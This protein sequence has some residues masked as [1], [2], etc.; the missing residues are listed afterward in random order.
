LSSL[1]SSCTCSG[2][3][4]SLP[5]R[6]PH[7]LHGLFPRRRT[8]LHYVPECLCIATAYSQTRRSSGITAASL[9]PADVLGLRTPFLAGRTSDDPPNLVNCAVIINLGSDPLPYV[10]PLAFLRS[11]S[12]ETHILRTL[13]ILDHVSV[14]A[15]E[16][17]NLLT[18][19]SAVAYLYQICTAHYPNTTT[20]SAY[21]TS[22][23]TRTDHGR[24][25]SFSFW[26]LSPRSRNC[27]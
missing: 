22:G 14:P 21:Y 9:D 4:S 6:E 24:R 20:G 3:S 25:I 7:D 2:R 13:D 5:P 1:S 11:L 26:K 10:A 19:S 12:L 27:I 18:S 17:L 15:L 8:V 16:V 23:L